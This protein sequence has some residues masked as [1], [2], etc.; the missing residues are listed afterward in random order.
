MDSRRLSVEM[1]EGQDR[2]NELWPALEPLFRQSCESNDI[3]KDE[4]TPESIKQLVLDGMCAVFVFFMDDVPSLVLAIQ[5][6]VTNNMKC[7]D[8][9]GLGGSHL[10][11]FKAAYWKTILSWLKANDIVFLDA[12]ANERMASLYRKKFGFNKS[13]S[14]VRMNLQESA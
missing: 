3:A 14:Y 9:I 8:I 12:Y 11:L 6:N 4:L 2:T 1:L 10:L 5:F 7:A 13:C